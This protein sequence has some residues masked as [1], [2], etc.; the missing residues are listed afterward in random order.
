[1]S[2]ICMYIYLNIIYN[3]YYTYAS[4]VMCKYYKYSTQKTDSIH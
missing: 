1:M 4:I 2:P 3:I